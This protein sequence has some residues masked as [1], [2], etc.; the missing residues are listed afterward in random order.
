MSVIA[1]GLEARWRLT[2]EFEASGNTAT[3]SD[4]QDWVDAE[5]DKDKPLRNRQFK[6]SDLQKDAIDYIQ[7]LEDSKEVVNSYTVD[8]VDSATKWTDVYN[9]RT[10]LIKELVDD[11]G[12]KVSKKY[13]NLLDDLVKTGNA[14]QAETKKKDAISTL[15]SSIAWTTTD[16]GYGHFTYTATAQNTSGYDLSNVS[17]TLALYDES[18]VRQGETYASLASWKNGETAKIEACGDSQPRA[19]RNDHR[20]LR[21]CRVTTAVT[22]YHSRH[23]AIDPTTLKQVGSIALIGRPCPV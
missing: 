13:Q 18:G 16:D 12:L 19:Y 5:L 17:I 22:R 6:D 10:A 2:N 14:A 9:K 11:H 8:S 3:S 21:D 4:Y 23:H 20:L 15:A 1:D 7:V